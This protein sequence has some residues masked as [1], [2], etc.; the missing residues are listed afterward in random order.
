VQVE[1]LRQSRDGRLTLVLDQSASPVRSLWAVMDTA[2]LDEAKEALR[3]RE[4]I[5]GPNVSK[6]IKA[7]ARGEAAP[8]LIIELPSWAESRGIDAV[9]WTALPPKFKAKNGDAPTIDEAVRYLGELTGE[10]RERAEKYIRF[11]PQQIDT[12]YRRKIEAEL[13]WTSREREQTRDS[14]N[15]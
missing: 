12:P 1:F 10:E 6:H 5:P 13:R 7:W 2:N 15:G 9:V 3:K 4:D 14:G 11:A 8:A